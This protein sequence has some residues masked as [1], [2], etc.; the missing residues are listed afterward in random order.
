MHNI[1]VLAKLL[2][3]RIYYVEGISTLIR[4]L[5]IIRGYIKKLYN[6]QTYFWIPNGARKTRKKI[7]PRKKF[8]CKKFNP[9]KYSTKKLNQMKFN[10][11]NIPPEKIQ[12]RKYSSKEK[13]LIEINST[14]KIFI[15]KKFN[16]GNIQQEEIQNG[17]Y[18]LQEILN[19]FL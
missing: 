3:K 11:E 4:N 8:N 19:F 16:P 2:E 18:S 17:K 7:I 5:A 1:H 13:N 15:L 14:W 10:P 6:L 9:R 12:P